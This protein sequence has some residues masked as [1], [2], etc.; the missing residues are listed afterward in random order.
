MPKSTKA[1]AKAPLSEDKAAELLT[2][3]AKRSLSKRAPKLSGALMLDLHGSFERAS[4]L[5][6]LRIAF[7]SEFLTIIELKSLLCGPPVG[8]NP[9]AA[10]SVVE[11]VFAAHGE[12]FTVEQL[13][14]FLVPV[15]RVPDFN[16][17]SDSEVAM[18]RTSFANVSSGAPEITPAQ[19]DATVAQLPGLHTDGPLSAAA[20]ADV[21]ERML[22]IAGESRAD[23]PSLFNVMRAHQRATRAPPTAQQLVRAFNA[24]DHENSGS[25]S[26]DRLKKVLVLFDGVHEEEIRRLALNECRATTPMQEKAEKASGG[27]A[28]AQRIDYRRL[29]ELYTEHIKNLPR[30]APPPTTRTSAAAT[31]TAGLAASSARAGRSA[32]RSA[33]AST[34]AAAAAAADRRRRQQRR[35][36]RW[37]RRRRRRALCRTLWRAEGAVRV[38]GLARAA[39]RTARRGARQRR[40]HSGG[41]GERR[42]SRSRAV[43]IPVI[44]RSGMD[45]QPAHVAARRPCSND[46]GSGPNSPDRAAARLI[47]NP[48]LI[49]SSYTAVPRCAREGCV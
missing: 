31:T 39:A 27:A 4:L 48:R 40:G 11:Q 22:E 16:E 5:T 3:A 45:A 14:A 33:V 43:A 38:G 6:A 15:R 42:R 37:R 36:R 10:S 25:L 19:L 47:Y 41:R 8:M 23:L 46:Q 17:L 28:A 12:C 9:A 30:R 7:T 35:R 26:Y 29:A 21:A 1:A 24:F 20:K 44:S 2:S 34:S 13:V 49:N 32:R 18:L